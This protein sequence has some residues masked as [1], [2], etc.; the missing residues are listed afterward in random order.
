MQSFRKA[1]LDAAIQMLF[2]LFLADCPLFVG[3]QTEIQPP[4]IQTVAQS[5]FGHAKDHTGPTSENYKQV[6]R[7]L[8][9]GWNTWDVNSV[10]TNVLLPEGLAIQVGL[11]HNT[12]EWGGAFLRD[13]LIG[14]LDP[15]AEKVIPGRHSWDG[16][17]TDLRVSWKGHSWRV[18]S[19][20][21]GEDLVLLASPLN[22]KSISALPP[23]IVFSVNFLWNRT[24]TT[25]RRP[26][27]IEAQGTS[28]VVR[29]YCTCAPAGAQGE[30]V[31]APAARRRCWLRFGHDTFYPRGPDVRAFSHF[32]VGLP[33]IRVIGVKRPSRT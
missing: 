12:T 5:R 28:K 32:H 13:V 30:N 2:M 24:G 31:V 23:T 29:I 6:Q 14:R 11:K 1:F 22:S 16:S 18:Q 26:E 21:D 4:T 9:R 20:H 8:A 33:S 27:F 25:V 19:A 15:G 3:A 7:R 10:T 17:Y